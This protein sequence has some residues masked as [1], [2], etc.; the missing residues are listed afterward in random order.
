MSTAIVQASTRAW[1]LTCTS[2]P[3]WHWEGGLAGATRKTGGGGPVSRDENEQPAPMAVPCDEGTFKR[4][5]F[6][7]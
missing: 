3:H 7:A 2:R 5:P 1:S 6:A 4:P